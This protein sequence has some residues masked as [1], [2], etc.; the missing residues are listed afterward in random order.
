MAG[1][2]LYTGFMGNELRKSRVRQPPTQERLAELFHVDTASGG[3]TFRVKRGSRAAGQRAGM[4]ND[5]GYRIIYVDGHGYRAHQ[6]V[7]LSATGEWPETDLD[8]KN[9][10]RDDNRID[11][12]RLATRGQNSANSQRRRR[13][14]LSRF[15]GVSFDKTRGKWVAQ[16]RSSGK[17]YNLGRFESEEAA[18]AAYQK[19]AIELFGEFA[20]F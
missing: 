2:L 4:L 12:L 6:L 7:W 13:E 15:K 10:A 17:V 14:T 19:A 3:V 11:N 9:G 8:H 5:S 20:R 1:S 16:I 18:A